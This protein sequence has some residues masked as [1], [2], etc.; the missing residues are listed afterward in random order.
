MQ[1]KE[2]QAENI[3]GAIFC[4][5]CGVRLEVNMNSSAWKSSDPISET[6]LVLITPEG[7]IVKIPTGEEIVVG[8]EDPISDIFPDLDLTQLGGMEKGVSRKH[9]IIHRTGSEYTLEDAGSTNGTFLNKK[10][11]EP[12]SPQLIKE[13]DELK[14]G[15]L[16][17]FVKAA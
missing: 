16:S 8:R 12:H 2:C 6:E 10:K 1:C 15:K 9:A 5:E 3:D 17:V 4:E 13:G 7:N 11:I 14:F